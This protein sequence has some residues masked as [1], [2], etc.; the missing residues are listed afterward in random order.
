M[1][2]VLSLTHMLDILGNFWYGVT[3]NNLR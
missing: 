2:P 1:Y 3:I